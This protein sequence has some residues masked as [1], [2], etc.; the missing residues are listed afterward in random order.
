MSS[1]P[2]WTAA[3][4]PVSAE[5]VVVAADSLRAYLTDVF[6][7]AGMSDAD[8]ATEATVMVQADLR[9]VGSHGIASA[10]RYVERLQ[11]GVCNPRPNLQVVR[12][13]GVSAVLDADHALGQIASVRGMEIAIAK[14]RQHGI[15]AVAVRN[16]S[17]NGMLASYAMMALEHDL[18]GMTT[19]NSPTSMPAVG[20][21]SASI[22]NNP[23]AFAI[24]AGRHAPIVVD[25]ATSVA[26]R[27][28]ILIAMKRGLPI[29][30]GWAVDVDG[31]P[32][33]DAQRAWEGL[34]FPLAGHKGFG[35]AMVFEVLSGVLSGGPFAALLTPVADT[36]S[37]RLVSHFFL[38]MDP[39]MFLDVSEFTARVDELIAL[40]KASDRVDGV[41][42]VLVP[43]ERGA[44]LEAQR[45]HEGIPLTP[46]VAGELRALGQGLG[47]QAP[48]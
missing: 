25:I 43:G 3:S 6:A 40:V 41:T 11:N 1:T 48:F 13:T 24:P 44:R 29:P 27:S 14:A 42:E 15:G 19:C 32:T 37:N 5:H 17:H 36:T 39:A 28:K 45:R 34:L 16:S 35:L 12:E 22:G 26:A 4:A 18:I 46:T 23:V 21:R 31:N 47:V 2:W 10:P 30:P 8:A 7:R 33:E 9:G 38:A 20:S